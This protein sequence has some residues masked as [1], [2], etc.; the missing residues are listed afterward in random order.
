M[1]HNCVM[2]FA[3]LQLSNQLLRLLLDSFT[4]NFHFEIILSFHLRRHKFLTFFLLKK[5]KQSRYIS[6]TREGDCRRVLNFH[7]KISLFFFLDK[8]ETKNQGCVKF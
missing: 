2:Q 7:K 1:T 3:K 5:K 6:R 8:K 4:E